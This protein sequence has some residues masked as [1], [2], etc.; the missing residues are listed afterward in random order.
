MS[1][2]NPEGREVIVD[3]SIHWF[4]AEG[5]EHSK[6]TLRSYDEGVASALQF[7]LEQVL[8][9]ERKEQS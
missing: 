7:A 1:I 6:L 2:E 9:A 3:V 5:R 4:T 8:T